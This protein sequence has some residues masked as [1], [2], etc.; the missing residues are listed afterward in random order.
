MLLTAGLL[1][2]SHQTKHFF[3]LLFAPSNLLDINNKY[4]FSFREPMSH[5]MEHGERISETDKCMVDP[6]LTKSHQ[7]SAANG[8][9]F[10]WGKQIQGGP[11]AHWVGLTWILRVCPILLGLMG[12]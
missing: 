9:H 5:A 1:N 7:N 10:V 4:S 6:S 3:G 2:F 12:I 8:V 11:S